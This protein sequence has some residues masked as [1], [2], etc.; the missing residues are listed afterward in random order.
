MCDQ[1][2]GWDVKLGKKI[3]NFARVGTKLFWRAIYC[4]NP[5]PEPDPQSGSLFRKR[6]G[7]RAPRIIWEY[8]L[9][10]AIAI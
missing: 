10:T 2:G 7:R 9:A 6:L 3:N 8:D 4:A 1:G 5:K